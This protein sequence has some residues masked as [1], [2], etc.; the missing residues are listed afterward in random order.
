LFAVSEPATL[1]PDLPGFGVALNGG[2]ELR[3]K[4][5]NGDWSVAIRRRV[6]DPATKVRVPRIVEAL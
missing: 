1:P 3:V 6:Q 2:G 4:R 5:D